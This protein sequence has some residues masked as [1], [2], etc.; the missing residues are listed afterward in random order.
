MTMK[1]CNSCKY[2]CMFVKSKEESCFIVSHKFM[3][4]VNCEKYK[5]GSFNEIKKEWK[6][7]GFDLSHLE[8]I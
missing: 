3:R 6:E 2:H 5:H 1:Q 7:K 8:A 4:N